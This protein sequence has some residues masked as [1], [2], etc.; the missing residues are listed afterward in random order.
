MNCLAGG[1]KGGAPHITMLSRRRGGLAREL[2]RRM[3]P[4]QGFSFRHVD[5]DSLEPSSGDWYV[6]TYGAGNITFL[7]LV[8]T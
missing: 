7:C 1:E 8:R 5:L 3:S 2:V 4:A 6:R